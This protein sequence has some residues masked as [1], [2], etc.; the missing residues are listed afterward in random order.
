MKGMRSKVTKLLPVGARLNAC[1]NG[2]AKTLRIVSVLNAKTRK[3]RLASAGVGDMVTVSVLTGRPDMR[4]K[5]VHAVIVRQKK[6][7][8][9]SD[10][11]R[12]KFEDNSAVV[13]KD[14]KGNPKGT[15]IKGPVAK[16]SVERWPAIGK[17]ASIVL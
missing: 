16:E 15:M 2:G 12:V 8:R 11:V 4:H 17:V 13:L 14:D 10:G 1:D 3:G 6:E 5:V 9:R 7:Y